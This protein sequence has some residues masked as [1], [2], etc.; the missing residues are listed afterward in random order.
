MFRKTLI[1]WFVVI[2]LVLSACQTATP[3]VAPTQGIQQPTATGGTALPTLTPTG[4]PTSTA[5]PKRTLVICVGSEPSSLYIYG[6]SA[7]GMWNILE[8]VYDG[9]FDTR[10]SV[11]QPVILEKT[12]SLS[13]GDAVLTPVAMKA[14]DTVVDQ[15]GNLVT[16]AAGIK[17]NPSGCTGDACGAAWDGKRALKL[18]QLKVT[19]KLKPGIKWSDGQPLTADDSVYSFELASAQETP[20]SKSTIDRTLSYKALDEVTVEWTGLPGFVPQSIPDLFY[21]PLPRHAWGKYK[22]ADLLTAD[23]S[24][25]HP[26]GWGPYVFD[27]WK[28]GDHISLHKNPNY[29]R[30]AEG[31]PKFDSLVF[32]FLGDQGGNNLAAL[33]AH[34]CDV[35]DQSVLLDNQLKSLEEQAKA[36]TIKV[37]YGQG[38]EW[39]HLDF[40]IRPSSYDDGFRIDKDRPDF[41]SD[42]RVRQAFAACIDRATLVQ[43]LFYG[44]TSVPGGYSNPSS[45][46]FQA[47]LK[48]LPYDPAAGAKLL[49]AAGW[50]MASNDPKTARQSDG[51]ST[52]PKGTPLVVNYYATNTPLRMQVAQLIAQ[53]LAGCG[54]QLKIQPFEI[55]TLFA[56]GPGGPL[57]GRNFDLTQFAWQSGSQSPCFLYTTGQIPTAKN[58]W[59][60]ANITGF[61]DPKYDAA[62]QNALQSGSSQ[63][64]SARLQQDAEQAFTADLPVLPLYFRLKIVATRPDF[65]GLEMDVTA[66]SALWGLEAYD[67]GPACK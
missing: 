29:F 51:S 26:L 50:K 2:S 64:D 45:P 3:P 5:L 27:E 14:G 15:S 67:Y 41:F 60:G 8:A 48:P 37:L 6:S 56:A 35:I 31:L 13:G 39:E 19:F 1:F 38:P 53:D 10:N 57:F 18:D 23:D 32:R 40:G 30:A 17:V 25:R 33:Q 42:L 55:G 36:G 43:T 11:A 59:L 22:P 47:A 54:I 34:E 28:A 52:V 49:D 62:C 21:V 16:L 4:L 58:N 44:H 66:R 61:S 24:A 46:L 12:P 65:C 63:A 7:V 9:P 20:V